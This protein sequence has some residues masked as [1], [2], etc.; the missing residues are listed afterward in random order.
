M[1]SRRPPRKSGAITIIG[2]PALDRAMK[3]LT[4]VVQK[5]VVRFAIRRAMKPVLAAAKANAP[6]EEGLLRSALKIRAAKRSRKAISIFVRIGEGDF[7]GE[8]FYG[9][10]Q[11]YGTRTIPAKGYLRQAYDEAGPTARDIALQGIRDGIERE[12]ARLAAKRAAGKA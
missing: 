9:A 4:P 7:R 8:T 6:H 1:A 3:K 5:K 2:V 12:A 11:E 10:F